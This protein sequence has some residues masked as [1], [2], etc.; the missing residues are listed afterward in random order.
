MLSS[1]VRTVPLTRVAHSA[2]HTRPNF[3]LKLEPTEKKVQLFLHKKAK[4]NKILGKNN[5]HYIVLQFSCFLM[6]CKTIIDV[7]RT[8]CR[9]LSV[10]Y[11]K[12]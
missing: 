1:L 12:R 10:C 6:K 11:L 3:T 4:M 8:K 7:F 5:I 9:A 2:V